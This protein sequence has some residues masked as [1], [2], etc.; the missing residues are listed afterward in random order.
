M[1]CFFINCNI[2]CYEGGRKKAEE[3]GAIFRLT[4]A[5]SERE[6]INQYLEELVAM[7]ANKYFNTNQIKI[8]LIYL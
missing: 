2:F 1:I 6:N 4:S 3:I 5:L 7:F 8:N